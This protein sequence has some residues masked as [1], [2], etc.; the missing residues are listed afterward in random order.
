[1]IIYP[2]V[3]TNDIIKCYKRYLICKENKLKFI[4]CIN[5]NLNNKDNLKCK[6]FFDI[7]KKYKCN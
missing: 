1:M 5:N 2:Y 3:F 7:I 4:E 6:E